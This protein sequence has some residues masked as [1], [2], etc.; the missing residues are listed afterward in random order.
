MILFDGAAGD[1]IRQVSANGGVADAATFMD[2]TLGENQ[3]AWPCFLPDGRHFFYLSAGGDNGTGWQLKLGA[4]GSREVVDLGPVGSRV[5]FAQPDLVLYTIE[6]TL[7]ARRLDTGSWRWRGDPFPVAERVQTTGT[8]R[9]H[10]SVS[11]NGVLVTMSGGLTERSELV[12]VDRSGRRLGREGAPGAYRDLALSL[13]DAGLAYGVVDPQGGNE[14]IW[15]R[16]LQ[17]GVASRLTFG[18]ANEIFPVWSPDGLRIAY[19]ARNRGPY[20]VW[21]RRADGTGEVDSVY[22]VGSHTGVMDWSRDGRTV[23]VTSFVAG[24]PDVWAVPLDGA[25]PAREIVGTRFS[26]SGGHLSPDARWLAYGSN[27]S[28]RNEIYV[29]AYPG[30]GGRWQVSTDGGSEPQ[31]RGD[32]QEIFYRGDGETSLMA[33]PVESGDAFRVG[34]PVKLFDAMLTRSEIS[35]NRY[36]ATSDGQ[37]F[38]LNMPLESNRIGVFDLVLNWTEELAR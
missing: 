32:G 11:D 14:D 4:L 18:E 15:V 37:R 21:A 33:V 38:L 10:F 3:H 16:D 1:S 27:E 30:P 13:D 9:S 22:S 6:S 31:W 8:G 25:G 29:R 23:I 36:V 17:R 5:E 12:W 28:G 19:S 34:T 20:E 24:N 35:R 26:E 7:M 2:R